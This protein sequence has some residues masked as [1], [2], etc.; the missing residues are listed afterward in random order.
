MTS[1]IH[2][3]SPRDRLERVCRKSALAG[4]RT[5][6][7][8]SQKEKGKCSR[9]REA[10]ARGSKSE[11]CQKRGVPGLREPIRRG[12]GKKSTRYLGSRQ[13]DA[14]KPITGLAKRIF[15]NRR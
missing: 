3:S 2:R 13:M 6:P 9:Y 1:E 15:R 8:S 12:G 10:I 14:Q 11:T 4:T 7:G 5:L